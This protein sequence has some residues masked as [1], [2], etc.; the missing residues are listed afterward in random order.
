M[1]IAK[2]NSVRLRTAASRSLSRRLQTFLLRAAG[3][4][5]RLVVGYQ[6]EGGAVVATDLHVWVE[7]AFS[8]VGWV[9]TEPVPALDAE[10]EAWVEANAAQIKQVVVNLA[11]NARDA[12]PDGG[13]L[14]ISVSSPVADPDGGSAT[15]SL[16]LEDTG[17]GI[18]EEIQSR[19]FDPFFSTK[20]VYARSD[21]DRL[22]AGTGLGLS[23]AY[24]I[25]R[26]HG[27]SIDVDTAP[28][29][30]ARFRIE[31][32]I[33]ASPGPDRRRRAEAPEKPGEDDA[34]GTAVGDAT[35]G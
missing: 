1:W 21:A 16:V 10:P 3:Y 19:V 11:L 30:G 33:D 18:P 25:V 6:S 35:D 2:L 22:L 13:R 31:L 4:P 15:T 7:V 34:A 20:G 5:A 27:G 12:M 32:P 24:G 26:E 8:D 29:E 23:V 9:A 28:G 17:Q 14:S